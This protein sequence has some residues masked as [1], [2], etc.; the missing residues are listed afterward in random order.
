MC[1]V[2][3][4]FAVVLPLMFSK[5]AL[6][7]QKRKCHLHPDGLDFISVQPPDPSSSTARTPKSA[8]GLASRKE[9]ETTEPKT[10]AGPSNDKKRKDAEPVKPEISKL[11][12]SAYFPVN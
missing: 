9:K 6:Q 12:R 5:V 11:Q 3:Y 7:A 2:A 8:P 1:G 10:K 4:P